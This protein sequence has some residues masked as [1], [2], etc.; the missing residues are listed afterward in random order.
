MSWLQVTHPRLWND[1]KQGIEKQPCPQFSVC[2]CWFQMAR[3][4]FC[5]CECV[6]NNN[7]SVKRIS[8]TFY[9]E[10]MPETI[11]SSQRSEFD[12]IFQKPHRL[13]NVQIQEKWVRKMVRSSA[14]PADLRF[15]W[16]G[17]SRCLC[18]RWTSKLFITCTHK[19][20]Y[21]NIETYYK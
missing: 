13:F 15:Y 9:E 18:M 6:F 21:T 10:N 16:N 1:I 2:I 11:F 3:F 17:L 20:T 12:G 19:H 7:Q 8:N 4:S 14:F 5:V